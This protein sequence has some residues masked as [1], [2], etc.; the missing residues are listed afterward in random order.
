MNHYYIGVDGG[1]T[2][3]RGFLGD[4]HG[5][6]VTQL[7]VESTNYLS[8][9]KEIAFKRL[10][11]LIQAICKKNY[12]S[13]SN[14]KGAVFG[15][16]GAGRENDKNLLFNYLTTI[17]P[18][19]KIQVEED[20]MIALLAGHKQGYGGVLVAGTGSIAISINRNDNIYRI[21]GNGHLIDDFGSGYDIGRHVLTAV[22]M[23]M[24]GRGR[25]T[26]MRQLLND[27]GY[28]TI[29]DIV[30]YIYRPDFTKKDIGAF[31]TIAF[32][33]YKQEDAVATEIINHGVEN[34]ANLGSTLVKICKEDNLSF[35]FHGGLFQ[36][37][38]FYADKVLKAIQQVYPYITRKQTTHDAA[39]GALIMAWNMDGVL[40]EV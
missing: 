27:Q 22:L 38:L 12:I 5:N 3:T 1:G 18:K 25:K 17:L 26:L 15:L 35:I 19:A 13:P 11:D 7:E 33:A 2:S 9:G 32:D 8:V 6:M 28:N 16:A 36:H 30:S 29:A 23:D 40:Y 24:D 14:I 37:Q 20:A 10:S 39:M 34:L 4:E 31:C 21:G